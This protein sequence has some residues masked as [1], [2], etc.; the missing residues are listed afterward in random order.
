MRLN[1][2]HAHYIAVQCVGTDLECVLAAFVGPSDTIRWR[3]SENENYNAQVT[4]FYKGVEMPN[5][6]SVAQVHQWQ[7]D[8]N[9]I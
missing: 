1:L 4:I 3:N 8:H 2:E 9:I 6:N 5:L 7:K